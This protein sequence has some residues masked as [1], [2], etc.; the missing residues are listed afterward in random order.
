MEESSFEYD[1]VRGMHFI[2][3]ISFVSANCYTVTD[4]NAVIAERVA[5]KSPISYSSSE[6]DDYYY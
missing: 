4:F 3:L 5:K 6:E 2:A 1:Y